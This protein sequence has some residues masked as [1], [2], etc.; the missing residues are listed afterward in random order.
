MRAIFWLSDIAMSEVKKIVEKRW[1]GV[2]EREDGGSVS[3]ECRS[4]S[5]GHNPI[6]IG[7]VALHLRDIVLCLDYRGTLSLQGKL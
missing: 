1:S 5:S 3:G 4:V 2:P 7:T 6:P